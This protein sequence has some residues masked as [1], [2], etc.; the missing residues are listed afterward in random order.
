MFVFFWILA[1]LGVAY[2]AKLAGRK[3]G[4]WFLLSML[5]SPLGGSVALMLADRWQR[6]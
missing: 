3:W 1:S 4:A 2:W 5:L 6:R